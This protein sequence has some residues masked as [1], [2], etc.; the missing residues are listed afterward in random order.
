MSSIDILVQIP[1]KLTRGKGQKS[2]MTMHLKQTCKLVLLFETLNVQN[3]FDN[4]SGIHRVSIDDILSLVMCVCFCSA[5][6]KD[7][8]KKVFCPQKIDKLKFHRE[9]K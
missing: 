8:R 7:N 3:F 5:I 9:T 4:F 1:Q 2:T 6:C